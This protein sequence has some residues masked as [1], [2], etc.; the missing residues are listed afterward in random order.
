VTSRRS[1]ACLIG[2]GLLGAPFAYGL[3]P[4]I[5]PKLKN[6]QVAIRTAIVLPARI[7]L[8]KVGVHGAES[9][10]EA[11]EKLS[12]TLYRLVSAELAARG[13]Q[14]LP[15]PADPAPPDA[16]KYAIADLQAK[17]DNVGVQ[18]RKNLDAIEKGKYSL[19]DR[20]ATFEPARKADVIV[21]IRARGKNL[22]K[23]IW[24]TGPLF[25]TVS[26]AFQA[27]IGLVDSHSGE[28][29]AFLRTVLFKNPTAKTE[30]RFQP[31]IRE[32]FRE[33]PFPTPAAKN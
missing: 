10:P 23:A 31:L 9:M 16:V 19:G 11:S 24:A 13:V 28:V 18:L 26:G 6:G 5:Q 1:F 4:H 25:A 17:Y 7:E 33:V 14:L 32:A 20:V 30:D 15:N 27:D 3:W 21:F 2:L 8:V 22:S 12:A 29:L